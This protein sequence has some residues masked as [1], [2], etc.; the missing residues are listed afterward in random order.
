MTWTFIL[1][2]L[3]GAAVVTVPALI[4]SLLQEQQHIDA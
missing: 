2:F 4:S 3:V 1:V